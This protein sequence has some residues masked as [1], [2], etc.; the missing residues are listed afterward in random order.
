VDLTARVREGFGIQ[1]IGVQPTGLGADARA[2]LWR[3]VIADGTSYAVTLSE[4]AAGH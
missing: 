3:G 1:L 4:A 2:S